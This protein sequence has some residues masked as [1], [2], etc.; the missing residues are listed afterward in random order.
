MGRRVRGFL[1]II[2]A[3]AA[4]VILSLL[5]VT[6][7]NAF[8]IFK[9]VKTE[10]KIANDLFLEITDSS[11]IKNAQN[12]SQLERIEIEFDRSIDTNTVDQSSIV[13]DP[14]PGTGDMLDWSFIYNDTT[15]TL[16][17]YPDPILDAVSLPDAV[18]Y[19]VTVNSNLKGKDGSDLREP[20]SW[21]FETEES[22]TGNFFVESISDSEIPSRN[23]STVDQ[24]TTTKTVDLW[25]YSMN[26]KAIY[27]YASESEVVITGTPPGSW[28]EKSG[29]EEQWYTDSPDVSTYITLTGED[30][31]KT[32]H[33]GF[34][35]GIVS[36]EARQLKADTI[37]LD[38][39]AP[40]VDAG[41]NETWNRYRSSLILNDATAKDTN[42]IDSSGY[43]WTWTGDTGTGTLTLTNPDQLVATISS[44]SPASPSADGT[45]YL[46][47]KATDVPGNSNPTN[48]ADPDFQT[49]S[50]ISLLVDTVPALPPVVSIKT[51]PKPIEWTAETRTV[52]TTPTWTWTQGGSADGAGVFRFGFKPGSWID[53]TEK[54]SYTHDEPL[55]PVDIYTL[56]VQEMDK[57]ENWPDDE[58]NGSFSVKVVDV[59][60]EQSEE[61]VPTKMVFQWAS[62]GHV[63]AYELF[64]KDPVRGYPS[65]GLKLTENYYVAELDPAETYYWYYV[66]YPN[67]GKP[68]EV[69]EFRFKTAN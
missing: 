9:A 38:T 21:S 4:V 15:K 25:V 62:A 69:G 43:S 60:P 48:P 54:T 56:Y 53:K 16:F 23:E 5:L 28:P 32:V 59:I 26:L 46:T 63:E 12:V 33:M 35:D 6:C 58:D 52:D 11:P 47:L 37:I 49:A 61:G 34:S 66:V 40:T 20:Y 45:Y 68:Y 14:A 41:Y 2:P 31:V 39:T 64:I 22:A 29:T 7:S 19:T 36:P 1:I 30:G 67:I 65:R 24:F 3:A 57:V 55:K 17:V 18:Q 50:R 51:N 27:F 10:M 13:F 8:D 44:I 42:G